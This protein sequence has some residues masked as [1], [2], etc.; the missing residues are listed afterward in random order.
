VVVRVFMVLV[1]WKVFLTTDYTDLDGLHSWFVGC[2]FL[3]GWFA[4]GWVVFF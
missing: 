3:V 2:W 1:F 4:G